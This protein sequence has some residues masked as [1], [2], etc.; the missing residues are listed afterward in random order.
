MSTS[1]NV[2]IGA[3]V[4]DGGVLSGGYL[5]IWLEKG[6]TRT[7]T[8]RLSGS[9]SSGSFKVALVE[10]SYY[11]DSDYPDAVRRNNPSAYNIGSPSSI[12]IGVNPY[13]P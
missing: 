5:H 7:F 4:D 6:Q 11:K 8:V 9:Y 10:H 13:F 3:K 12:K 2:I 1:G